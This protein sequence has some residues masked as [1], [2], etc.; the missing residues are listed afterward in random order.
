[1]AR[2]KANK[3]PLINVIDWNQADQL[4]RELGEIQGNI[5]AI[6]R[7]AGDAI[8]GIKLALEDR[9]NEMQGRSH[10]I[11]KSLEEFALGRTKDFGEARSRKLDFGILGW[12][13]SSAIK[14]AE[15]TLERIKQFFTTAKQK[16]C[17]RIK[18]SV[19][20]EALAKLTDD[21]LATI[22]ARRKT[23]DAFFVEP[24]LANAADHTK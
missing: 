2:I 14:I 10:Y 22:K 1:M 12:R 8:N 6:E 11:V 19:D 24:I 7:T 5:E 3:E 21:E 23:T 20:K 13:S 9:V 15:T 17:I 18:E 16:A 4:V